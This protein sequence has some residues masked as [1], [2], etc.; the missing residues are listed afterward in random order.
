M[1]KVKIKKLEDGTVVVL[2]KRLFDPRIGKFRKAGNQNPALILRDLL[3]RN[4]SKLTKEDEKWFKKM[5]S[6]C[7]ENIAPLKMKMEITG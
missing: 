4:G 3:V 1:K 5:A 7:D 6:F 2:G